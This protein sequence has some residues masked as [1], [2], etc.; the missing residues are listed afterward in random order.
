MVLSF[1]DKTVDRYS[2]VKDKNIETSRSIPEIRESVFSMTL[3]GHHPDRD[4]GF[5][6]GTRLGE[7]RGLEGQANFACSTFAKFS[8]RALAGSNKN[9]RSGEGLAKQGRQAGVHSEKFN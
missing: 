3:F 4:L 5:W 8:G 1:K 6:L 2:Q 7:G 9:R